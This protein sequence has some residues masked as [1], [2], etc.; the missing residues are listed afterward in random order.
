MFSA[1]TL[2]LAQ[3]TQTVFDAI[4]HL[5]PDC[6]WGAGMTYA[7]QNNLPQDEVGQSYLILRDAQT[8][9]EEYTETLIEY[10]APYTFAL[11]L[12][13]DNF[14]MSKNAPKG[15]LLPDAADLSRA[16]KRIED[17]RATNLIFALSLKQIGTETEATLTIATAGQT[18]PKLGA[19]LFKWFA[20]TP[21][22]TLL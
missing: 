6:K 8:V 7:N 11:S 22:K 9:I 4:L 12:T 15:H 16:R 17:G 2:R 19:G 18:A 10:A 14:A 20:P 21:A 13:L 5:P 3:P 1:H